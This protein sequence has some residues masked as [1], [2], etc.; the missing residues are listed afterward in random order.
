M[1]M[2]PVLSGSSEMACYLELPHILCIVEIETFD[3][4]ILFE[5]SLRVSFFVN[6]NFPQPEILIV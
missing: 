3:P 6:V 4:E 5:L 1:L 2:S